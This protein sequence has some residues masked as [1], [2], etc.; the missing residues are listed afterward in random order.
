M[1]NRNPCYPWITK[2]KTEN[3]VHKP[4]VTIPTN[5]T[6]PTNMPNYKRQGN[7]QSDD[8]ERVTKHQPANF[9]AVNHSSSL[10]NRPNS[11]NET[12]QN[13]EDQLEWTTKI[14]TTGSNNIHF[15]KMAEAPGQLTLITIQRLP[16]ISP[17]LIANS[18]G[19]YRFMFERR[20]T[21]QG[22]CNLAGSRGK[23]LRN[24]EI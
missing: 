14:P 15:E 16:Y 21:N 22:T 2:W 7:H 23:Y 12:T 24:L 4:T 19:P 1:I 17:Q 6:W 13:I 9:N 11:S 5:P 8:L 18:K 10:T 3:Q 20:P